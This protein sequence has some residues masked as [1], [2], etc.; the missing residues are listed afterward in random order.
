MLNLNAFHDPGLPYVELPPGAH[1]AALDSISMRGFKTLEKYDIFSP[2]ANGSIT[3]NMLAF[4][5]PI[6]RTPEYTGLTVFNA[7]D[8][9]DDETLVR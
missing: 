4:A 1:A 7:V 5:H 2:E 3:A 6:H 9:Y 8:G